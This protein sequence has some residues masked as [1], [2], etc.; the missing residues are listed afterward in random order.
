MQDDG[1]VGV[2]AMIYS[3]LYNNKE[4]NWREDHERI[5]C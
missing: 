3:L 2:E 4:N 1:E 5:H